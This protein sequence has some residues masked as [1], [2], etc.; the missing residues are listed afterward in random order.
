M[1]KLFVVCIV[2]ICL[3]AGI[4]TR[5]AIPDD[6]ARVALFERYVESL[7]RSTHVPGLSGIII[8]DGRT[9]WLK[10][11]GFQDIESRVFAAPDTLKKMVQAGE[12][13]RK[14]GKGF[15]DYSGDQP[16]P[17]DAGG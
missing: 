10:G 2:G 9:L 17:V 7:R 16:V 8:R 5:A 13:G 3:L 1:S 15:Y 4:S 12:Y 6:D 11:W 14:S